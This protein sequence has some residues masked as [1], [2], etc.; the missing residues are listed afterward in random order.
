MNFFVFLEVW[1]AHMIKQKP[2]V[3]CIKNLRLRH[4]VDGLRV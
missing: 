2:K 1:T 3:Y 4:T